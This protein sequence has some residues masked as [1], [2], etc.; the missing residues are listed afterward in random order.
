MNLMSVKTFILM[1]FREN[2]LTLTSYKL[3]LVNCKSASVTKGPPSFLL[4]PKLIWLVALFS[5]Y[6]LSDFNATRFQN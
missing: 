3:I 4:Q 6:S 2:F 1:I 5:N